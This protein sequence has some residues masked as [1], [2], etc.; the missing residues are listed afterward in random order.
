MDPDPSFSLLLWTDLSGPFFTKRRLYD[1]V[2]VCSTVRTCNQK[3]CCNTHNKKEKRKKKK[4]LH[5][6]YGKSFR[7]SPFYYYSTVFIPELN[8]FLTCLLQQREDPEGGSRA[9]QLMRPQQKK[10]KKKK[11]ENVVH[12]MPYAMPTL[13]R[14]VVVHDMYRYRRDIRKASLPR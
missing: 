8:C 1:R 3:S 7:F 5:E 14:L 11:K 6:H 12:A 2:Y 10:K 9:Q 13:I 4:G